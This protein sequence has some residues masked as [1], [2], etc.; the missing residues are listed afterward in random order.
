MTSNNVIDK[1][2]G[3]MKVIVPPYVYKVMLGVYGKKHTEEH[4]IKDKKVKK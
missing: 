1:T 4:Y 3:R 2:T